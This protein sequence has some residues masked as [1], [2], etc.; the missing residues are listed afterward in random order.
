MWIRTTLRSAQLRPGYRRRC[1][2]RCLAASAALPRSRLLAPLPDPMGHF[3]VGDDATG[4]GIGKATLDHHAECQRPDQL[5]MRAVVGLLLQQADEVFFGC[6]H[7]QTLAPTNGKFQSCRDLAHRGNVA[8]THANST[9]P[10][11]RGSWCTAHESIQI[12]HAV[13]G[14]GGGDRAASA[15]V[16]RRPRAHMSRMTYHNIE[17]GKLLRRLERRETLVLPHWP[18]MSVVGPG[19]G[20]T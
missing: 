12:G 3:V 8:E 2:R 19:C 6:G 14:D 11:G 10:T 5:L 15:V 13:R 20:A 18:P 16:M 1:S 17:A 4:I 9:N 7:E